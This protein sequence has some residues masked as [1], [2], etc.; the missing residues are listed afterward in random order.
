MSP[1]ITSRMW[2]GM[3]ISRMSSYKWMLKFGQRN[4][5]DTIHQKRLENKDDEI[6]IKV[7]K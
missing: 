5:T 7:R 6:K 1:S 4:I 3:F 2:T